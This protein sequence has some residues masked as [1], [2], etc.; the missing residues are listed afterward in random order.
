MLI[1][2]G[3]TRGAIQ[4]AVGRLRATGHRVS[5]LHLNFL[6]PM[7]S[8]ID[9]V[10]KRFDRV[11][12]IEN[13][14]NDPVSDPLIDGN[15]RRYSHLAMLLRSRWLVD[16]DCWG[17]ARGQPL[18]PGAIHDAALAKLVQARGEEQ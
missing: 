3:S 1:G 15:N 14:W 8:G 5:S 9:E 17:N 18:K 16:V 7:A 11:M 13:N 10:M 12:T 2:W 6:Q 4:E